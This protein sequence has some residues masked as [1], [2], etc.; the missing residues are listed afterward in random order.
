VIGAT[1]QWQEPCSQF[2]GT[3]EDVI[4]FNRA[5]VQSELPAC[6]FN[7]L[8]G[9]EPGLV[10]LFRMNGNG[11]DDSP[12]HNHA[13]PSGNVSFTPVYHS[14]WTDGD[15]AFSYLSITSLDGVPTPGVA[16]PSARLMATGPVITRAQ[17]ITID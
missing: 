13:A 2:V 8:T 16:A 17:S 11:N 12:V 9:A 1:D 10:G 6:M 5:I 7:L 3:S 15:N 14:V 4:L